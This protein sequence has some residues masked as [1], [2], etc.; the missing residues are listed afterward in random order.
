MPKQ[1]E[2]YE[3]FVQDVYKV[4]NANDG[5]NDVVVQHNVK[6]KGI[7][8]EHQIDVYWQFS[9]GTV[10]YRVAVECKDYQ[11]PVT[12]EKIEAFRSTLLDIGN[13]QGIFASRSG[14]QSGAQQ[15]AMAYGIQ[16]M[17]IREPLSSDWD[18]YIKDIYINY[19]FRN[20][21]NVRPTI[22][23]DLEWAEKNKIDKEKVAGFH[24]DPKQTF[25]V[26]N[27]GLQTE[28]RTSFSELINKLPC[29]EEGSNKVFTWK[30]ENAYFECDNSLMKIKG[31]KIEYDVRFSHEQRHFNAMDM[32]KAVVNNVITGE[33]H[34]INIR[35]MVS[36]FGG[37][38]HLISN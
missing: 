37:K 2:E 3:R 26:I 7:S 35:N 8:R 21:Q 5:L 36:D 29:D 33:S 19:T 30:Y 11:K 17:Q 31:I 22:L 1:G 14:F 20:V 9:Y 27:R 24:S 23:V 32:A 25:V 15:V 16:L 34:L 28:C 18:G 13:I 12:A 6:L 38:N 4:L 10:T